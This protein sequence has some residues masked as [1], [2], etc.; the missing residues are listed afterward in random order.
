MVCVAKVMVAGRKKKL[1][2]GI[3]SA[4]EAIS[5]GKS[6]ID[7]PTLSLSCG[8]ISEILKTALPSQSVLDDSPQIVILRNPTELLLD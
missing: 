2:I 6:T 7:E 5:N 4:P 8:T 1:E 3:V